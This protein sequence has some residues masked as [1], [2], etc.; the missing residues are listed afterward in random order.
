MK[1]LL[2]IRA[3]VPDQA[4]L[5]DLVLVMAVMQT[6]ADQYSRL[7]MP[8]P[9]WVAEKIDSLKTEI[10]ARHRDFIARRLKEARLKLDRLKTPAEQRADVAKEIA[11]LEAQ[12]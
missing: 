7:A 12:L 9:N 5:D 11:D 4:D 3:F 1:M 6:V 8:V 10:R 2:E